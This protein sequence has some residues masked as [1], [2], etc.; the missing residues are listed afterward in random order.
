[1]TPKMAR[2]TGR[3]QVT[4]PAGVRKTLGLRAG[5]LVVFDVE[6][7]EVRL[8]KAMPR[9]EQFARGLTGALGEWATRADEEAFREL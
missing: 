4:I 6:G 5:D 7:G 2:L 9:D 1:M 8:R 3:Y